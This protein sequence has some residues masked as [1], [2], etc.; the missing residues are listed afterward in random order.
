MTGDPSTR[1]IGPSEN[2]SQREAACW[3]FTESRP[4]KRRCRVIPFSKVK[5]VLAEM[6]GGTSGEHLSANRAIDKVRQLN[7]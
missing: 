5:E 1:A 6:H 3:N 7:Y 2:P 4:T